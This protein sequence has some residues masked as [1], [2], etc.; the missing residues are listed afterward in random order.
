MP[1]LFCYRTM[2][3][4]YARHTKAI[5]LGSLATI[6]CSHLY[7]D[8]WR[9]RS[10]I[11]NGGWTIAR[12]DNFEQVE[13]YI[14]K[15]SNKRLSWLL[16]T[17]KW[18]QV[19]Y[20]AARFGNDRVIESLLDR[21]LIPVDEPLKDGK[22]ALSH[23]T[24]NGK[25]KTM[26][27]LLSRGARLPPAILFDVYAGDTASVFH[28]LVQQGADLNARM[29]G[30]GV[31]SHM[32]PYISV[33][34]LNDL[35]RVLPMRR[36][37]MNDALLFIARTRENALEKIQ[38]LVENCGVDV[39]VR[40]TGNQVTPLLYR[41]IRGD[42][43]SVK[44]LMQHGAT[45]H[46][47]G[48]N[49]ILHLIKASGALDLL[50]YCVEEAGCSVHGAR[51][52]FNHGNLLFMYSDPDYMQYVIDKGVPVNDDVNALGHTP[53][54]HCVLVRSNECVR[55]LLRNGAQPDLSTAKSGSTPLHL[56][57]QRGYTDKVKLLLEY[58]AS[59][60]SRDAQGNTP[61]ILTGAAANTAIAKLL[62]ERG[63]NVQATNRD[64]Y[65]ALSLAHET[66]ARLKRKVDQDYIDLLST[67]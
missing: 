59:V 14:R 39:S 11:I 3:R 43:P 7:L 31:L 61:L 13:S 4:L 42:L 18:H 57:V 19:Y 45:M 37:E 6:S 64:G 67:V 52:K 25:L 22:T 33:Q 20:H 46:D 23:A 21:G 15:C 27:L 26:Q 2:I 24:R 55:V 9:T 1:R 47:D 17:P 34:A 54:M 51:K 41:A 5:V 8:F 65:T 35:K 53:L 63:A 58:G 32:V 36:H 50:K 49:E 48:C 29:N 56:A 12:E 28:Y 44:Y 62:I 60:D 66:S 40:D 16:P 30:R 10:D 38:W